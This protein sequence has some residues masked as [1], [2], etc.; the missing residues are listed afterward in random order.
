MIPSSG[1]YR[2][3]HA[4]EN[5]SLLKHGCLDIG[6]T[7]N[8]SKYAIVKTSDNIY[9]V[10]EDLQRIWSIKKPELILSVIGG[11]QEF[12]MPYRIRKSLKNSLVKL[13]E[14]TNACI[15]TDGVHNGVAKLVGEA[16]AQYHKEENVILIGIHNFETIHAREDLV[17]F[18]ILLCY[19]SLRIITER[20]NWPI[21]KSN[22]A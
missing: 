18:F 9:E 13:V 11:E 17:R 10:K 21:I 14:F 3:S 8:E 2:G 22:P 6:K 4:F 15:I 12:S 1:R 5:V 16:I 20:N 7:Y 19:I